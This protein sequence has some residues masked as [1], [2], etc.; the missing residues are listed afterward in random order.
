MTTPSVEVTVLDGA[1]GIL[2]ASAGKILA[3]M[4]PAVSGTKNLAGTYGRVQDL[5][6]DFSGGAGVEAAA[7]H[8][9]RTGRPVL[10]IRTDDNA[11][12]AAGTVDSSGKAGTSV[13]T[14]DT[15]VT[16]PYDDYEVVF[17][18]VLGGTIATGPITFR[19][20][21]DD[22]NNYSGD[23]S[24]GVANT[25][26]IPDSGVILDFAAGTLITGDVVTFR[27]T[28]PTVDSTDLGAAFDALDASAAR[29]GIVEIASPISTSGLVSTI[30]TKMAA[31]FAKGKYR[32]FFANFRMQNDGESDATYQAAFV[33]ALSGS[34]SRYGSICAGDCRMRSGVSGRLYRRPISFACAS[35]EANISEEQNAANVNLGSL[36]VSI[37]DENGNPV[38]HDEFLNPGLD[39]A[40]SYTLRTWGDDLPGVYVNRPKLFSATGSDYDL[41]PHLRVLNL[42]CEAARPYFIRRLNAP[43]LVDRATG[44]LLE[45][46]AL[47]MEAGALAVLSAALTSKPK[48]SDV[49]VRIGR[50][51]NILSDKTIEVEIRIIPLAYPEFVSITIGFLNPAL[52]VQA[53]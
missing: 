37:R 11:D 3:V 45:E 40:R 29:W 1:L 49:Q 20:S 41:F 13:V 52:Q 30:N 25:Y 16:K 32:E 27:T 22:G 51:N 47:E 12:G 42:G 10:F 53:V 18:V 23:I 33:T 34:E 5:V 24:L 2:P 17:E 26:T 7:A 19:Y 21:L 9:D 15:A 39:D 36:N 28:G 8:I 44:F 38:H 48:A 6:S 31:M 35:N 4:G 50:L 14:V 43:V 46:E